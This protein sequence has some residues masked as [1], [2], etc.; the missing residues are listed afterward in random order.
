MS[1]YG[2]NLIIGTKNF[3]GNCEILVEVHM[4]E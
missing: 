2:N 4:H 3:V 1:F